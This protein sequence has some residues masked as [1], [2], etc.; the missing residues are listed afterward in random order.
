MELRTKFHYAGR[1]QKQFSSQSVQN[2]CATHVS[3]TEKNKSFISLKRKG[4]PFPNIAW[5]VGSNGARNK[6]QLC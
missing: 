5:E 6:E 3:L 4:S 1:D 2:Y